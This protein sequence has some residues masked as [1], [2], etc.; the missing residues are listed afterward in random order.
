MPWIPQCDC[1]C[2]SE[3][4]C[5]QHIVQFFEE[6]DWADFWVASLTMNHSSST[7][8]VHITYGYFISAPSVELRLF[9]VQ[10]STSSKLD[11][12]G[13]PLDTA[14]TIKKITYN[15]VAVNIPKP[16]SYRIILRAVRIRFTNSP[17]TARLTYFSV[18]ECKHTSSPVSKNEYSPAI[19]SIPQRPM[20]PSFPAAHYMSLIYEQRSGECIESGLWN[21]WFSSVISTTLSFHVTFN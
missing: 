21:L 7:E 15:C 5:P 10:S 14:V 6:I 8:T 19:N 3:K 18:G 2:C 9:L 12:F 4:S 13:D 20:P 16:G 1:C 17:A 11:D